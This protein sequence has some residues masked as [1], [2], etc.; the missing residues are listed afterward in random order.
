[1]DAI[2]QELIEQVAVGSVEFDA[3]EAG[4]LGVLGAATEGFDDA[5]DLAGFERSWS[6]EG[7][8]RAEKADVCRTRRWRW[9]LQ[10]VVH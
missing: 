9:G 2:L 3:I 7:T 4:E 6:N 5:R 1:M 8:L 10:E